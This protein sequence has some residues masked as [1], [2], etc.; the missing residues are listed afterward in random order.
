MFVTA[1]STGTRNP[2]HRLTLDIVDTLTTGAHYCSVR[3]VDNYCT[4]HYYRPSADDDDD[5]NDDDDEEL[6][7]QLQRAIVKHYYSV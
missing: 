5:A 7:T 4:Q 1:C 6:D 3:D 2:D